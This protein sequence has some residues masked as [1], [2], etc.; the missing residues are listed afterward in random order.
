MPAAL[1]AQHAHARHPWPADAEV[2]VRIGLH[3]GEPTVAD[4]GYLGL[5]VH[6]AARICGLAHGGQIL[7]SRATRELVADEAA[8]DLGEIALKGLS[9]P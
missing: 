3:T 8:R 4:T 6:R 2:R 7:L 9:R 1:A 5:E